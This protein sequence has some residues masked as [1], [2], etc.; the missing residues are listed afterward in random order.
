MNLPIDHVTTAGSDLGRMQR[1]FADAGLTTDYGGLHSNGITHM[2]MLGFD[3]GSYV[4]LISTLRS[5]LRAP[6]WPDQIAR[7]GG[8][9]AWCVHVPSLGTEC[10]RLRG[11]GVPVQGPT[12]YHRDRPDGQRVEWELAV[13]GAGQPGA[14]LPFLIRDRT[15]RA[16]RVR[17]SASVSGTELT[18]VASVVIGVRDL[19]WSTALFEQVYGWTPR[20]TRPEPALGATVVH[21]RHTP[22][23]LAAPIRARGWLAARLRQFGESPVA[24]LLRSRSLPS[25]AARLPA[26]QPGRWLGRPALWLDPDPAC[27]GRLGITEET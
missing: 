6:W 14:V 21:L 4:E 8:P 12:A 9:C 2:A 10:E 22:I 7:N 18:G 20:E 25:S 26:A 19:A 27:G 17:P 13:L 5:G 16:L 3:D 23:A 24:F 1:A 15:P 11:A